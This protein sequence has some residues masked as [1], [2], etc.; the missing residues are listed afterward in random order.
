[1]K[2]D[3]LVSV[4]ESCWC[5]SLRQKTPSQV[6]ETHCIEKVVTFNSQTVIMSSPSENIKCDWRKAPRAM[7]L[8]KMI[9]D[10][11]EDL[12]DCS[13]SEE[14]CE[15]LACLGICNYK[16]LDHKKA[17]D[18]FEQH[19]KLA[20]K[21]KDLKEH[22]MALCNLGCVYKRTNRTLKALDAFEDGLEIADKIQDQ[23]GKSKLLQN[24]GSICETVGEF[25]E[26]INYYKQRL[27]LAMELKDL[28]GEC[29]A[30]A[31]LGSVHHTLGDLRNSIEY[32]ERAVLCLRKKQ[33]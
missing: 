13:S 23:W 6:A 15:A 19:L 30:C 27:G 33:G 4:F 3:K 21:S 26:A 5:F 18:Y 25:D 16:L 14:K 29:K 7:A 9:Q 24:L 1:M 17:E 22:K 20:K 28:N 2:C 12:G 8:S 11:Q 31:C 10:L 32:Y